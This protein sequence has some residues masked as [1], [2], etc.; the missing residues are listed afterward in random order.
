MWPRAI[1]YLR[2]SFRT[3]DHNGPAQSARFERTS[4]SE[5]ERMNL[6]RYAHGNRG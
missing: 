2:D 5:E 1:G 3:I 6:R 4:D